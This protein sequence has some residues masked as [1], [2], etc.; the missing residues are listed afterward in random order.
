MRNIDEDI[1][2]EQGERLESG[3]W[4][5]CPKT[6]V[7]LR[8]PKPIKNIM[9]TTKKEAFDALCEIWHFEGEE[10]ELFCKANNLTV[11]FLNFD[12]VPGFALI[13]SQE[14]GLIWEFLSVEK[15]KDFFNA[16]V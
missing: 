15:C 5:I 13:V 11:K 14:D 12:A 6:G 9:K 4:H 1:I 7:V 8:E 3:E 2:Q 10:G 16:L